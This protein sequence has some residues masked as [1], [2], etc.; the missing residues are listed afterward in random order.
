MAHPIQP[1]KLVSHETVDVENN[2]AMIYQSGKSI[3]VKRATSLLVNERADT[4]ECHTLLVL[5]FNL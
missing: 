5:T 4:I 1:I 3:A 2:R